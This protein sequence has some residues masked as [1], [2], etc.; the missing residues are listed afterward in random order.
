M[1]LLWFWHPTF[2]HPTYWQYI[3]RKVTHRPWLSLYLL[4]W[5]ITYLI[6]AFYVWL[7]DSLIML[8][9]VVVRQFPWLWYKWKQCLVWKLSK[10]STFC[11]VYSHNF[12]VLVL[13]KLR[14]YK[15]EW[16]Q[17]WQHRGISNHLFSYLPSLCTSTYILHPYTTM[18]IGFVLIFLIQIIISVLLFLV[19]KVFYLPFSFFI[20]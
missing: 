13:L 5:H 19:M 10:L 4:T 9:K 1:Y 14:R 18:T 17:V 8:Y 16:W 3:T 15:F 7:S 6:V 2:A 11:K 20:L 12:F